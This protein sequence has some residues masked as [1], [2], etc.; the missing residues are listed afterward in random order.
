MH[1]LRLALVCWTLHHMVLEGVEEELAV[2]TYIDNT[3]NAWL[4][5][6]VSTQIFIARATYVYVYLYIGTTPPP[7][8]PLLSFVWLY[9]PS[10]CVYEHVDCLFW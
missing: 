10:G 8:Q 1:G 5:I 4:M 6:I 9:H 3:Y 7:L 2:S